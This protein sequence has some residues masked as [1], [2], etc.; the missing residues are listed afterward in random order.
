MEDDDNVAV[1]D[2]DIGGGE[3][4][5]IQMRQLDAVSVDYYLSETRILLS[6]LVTEFDK[7]PWVF[8]EKRDGMTLFDCIDGAFYMLRVEGTMLHGCSPYSFLKN[9]TSR[10]AEGEG[11]LYDFKWFLTKSRYTRGRLVCDSKTVAFYIGDP[12]DKLTTPPKGAVA[13]DCMAALEIYPER[14]QFVCVIRFNPHGFLT[15]SKLAQ[16]R[17][18]LIDKLLSFYK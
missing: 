15:F 13:M 18:L 1:I 17:G 9:A 10:Y 16:H 7:Y 2:I 12:A 4:K 5:G 6:T 3:D 14:N 8:C 11:T